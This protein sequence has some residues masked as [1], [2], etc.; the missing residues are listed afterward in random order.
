[1]TE[2]GYDFFIWDWPRREPNY[3]EGPYQ[4]AEGDWHRP[5][6]LQAVK[7]ETQEN[8]ERDFTQIALILFV[9]IFILGCYVV[10]VNV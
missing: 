8:F 5:W 2:N 6:K 10:G 4:F 9:F 7:S 3:G 1:M